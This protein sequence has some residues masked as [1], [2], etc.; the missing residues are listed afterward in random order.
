MGVKYIQTKDDDTL[1]S[2]YT[3]FEYF[4]VRKGDKAWEVVEQTP[5]ALGDIPIIEYPANTSR[6]GKRLDIVWGY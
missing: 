6:L 4:E 5:H 3:P 2:V 1:F